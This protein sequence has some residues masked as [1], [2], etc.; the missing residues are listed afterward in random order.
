MY[1]IFFFSRAF[2]VYWDHW[3]FAQRNLQRREQGLQLLMERLEPQGISRHVWSLLFRL[4]RVAHKLL[5]GKMSHR[6]PLEYLPIKTPKRTPLPPPSVREYYID[7]YESL[8][9]PLSYHTKNLL[10]GSSKETCRR[11]HALLLLPK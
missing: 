11:L 7:V 6:H 9:A 2:A 5:G 1:D 8:R 4:K 10:F 3:G